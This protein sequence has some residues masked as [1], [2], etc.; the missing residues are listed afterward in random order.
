MKSEDLFKYVEDDRN[1]E[2]VDPFAEYLSGVSDDELY[3][4]LCGIEWVQDLDDVWVAA[5][6]EISRMYSAVVAEW[7]ERGLAEKGYIEQADARGRD[8]LNGV[9]V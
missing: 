4:H 2:P 7:H 5:N 1:F 9:E 3:A 6:L 8:A